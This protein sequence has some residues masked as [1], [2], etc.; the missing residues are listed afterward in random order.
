MILTVGTH[1]DVAP[2]VGLG[3]RLL[4]AGHQVVVTVPER[5][6]RLVA[7]AGLEHRPLDV[8][9][10]VRPGTEEARAAH[11][12]GARGTASV[13]R[14]AVGKMGRLVPAMHAAADGANIVLC[15][16]GTA[17]AAMPIAEAHGAPCLLVPFQIAE[18]TREFGPT[19]LGGRD[20]GPWLNR[21]VPELVGRLGM[22]AFAGLIREVRADLGLPA[23]VAPAYRS[24]AVP[25]L[26]GISPAVVPRPADW[27]DNVQLAGY[28][29]SPRPSGWRPSE[30]LE[31]FLAD[32]PPPM[33]VGFG[34]VSVGK[35]E[36]L[37]RAVLDAIHRT[38]MRAVVQRGWEGLDV[39][40]DN[41]FT[42]DEVPHD[43]LFPR[44]A[45]AVHHAGAGTTAATLRAGIP[46]VPVPFV[47]DQGFWARRLV[48]L[49][50]A[51]RAIPAA[52][53]SG[54]RLA[55][56]ITSAA[57]ESRFARAAAA[58]AGRIAEEDGAAPVLAA[59]DRLVAA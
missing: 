14:L 51:P 52:R 21:A 28:W 6:T 8:E 54:G 50:A 3:T 43:W 48:T 23:E 35:A 13:I 5:L 46:S 16:F 57:T 25:T 44:V 55:A 42:I 30:D 27:R 41:I 45:A 26:Y 58:I 37:S 34:S 36:S 33:Y 19:F 53:L 2:L 29:W 49:G 12:P 4:A 24:G 47:Y 7:D 11:R 20:L 17:P 59:I 10:A 56:A 22:R 31:C 1:G 18:P 39:S 38:G 40:G 32:G 15:T 9:P